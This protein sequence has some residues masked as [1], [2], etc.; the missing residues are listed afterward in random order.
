VGKSPAQ[1]ALN[2][3]ANRPG[4]TST[5]IGATKL[6][7][8]QDNFAAIEFQLPPEAC[9]KLEEASRLDPTVHP[10]LFFTEAMQ[11]MVHGGVPVRAWARQD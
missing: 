9:A 5:I 7:Q 8:L 1:V 2:W 10:Y 11:S 6:A 4:I 3:V